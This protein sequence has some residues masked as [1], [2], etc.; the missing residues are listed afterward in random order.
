[1]K[2]SGKSKGGEFVVLVN[3]RWCNA[4]HGVCSLDTEVLAVSFCP[5]YL[6]RVH[7]SY[8][9]GQFKEFPPSAGADA[10][11][12]IISSAVAKLQ[13]QQPSVFLAVTGDFNHV[14]L[15]L[16]LFQHFNSL[17]TASPEK[18]SETQAVPLHN[19]L[20]ADLIH[21]RSPATVLPR[22]PQQ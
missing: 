5:Y 8:Y 4:G 20:W 12:N 18:M 6:Q 3:N 15:S 7:Q 13:T 17:S 16:P 14:P 10:A 9:S 2:R 19:L 1:M 11:C 21:P 22:R